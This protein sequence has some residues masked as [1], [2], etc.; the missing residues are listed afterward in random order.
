MKDLR[1]SLTAAADGAMIV[2]RN[3]AVVF[4]NRAA[5]RLLGYRAEEV[6]GRRCHEI[7]RGETIGGHALCSPS[8]P[9]A[10]RIACG[11]GVRNFDMLTHT[12]AGRAI[13]LNVSSFP[14]P[15][16]KK[17]QFVA[18][19]LFR[20]I[21]KLAKVRRIVEDLHAELCGGV[22]KSDEPPRGHDPPETPATLPLTDREREVLDQVARGLDNLSI[23]RRL[24]LSPKTVRNH[25][26]NI[27]TKLQVADRAQAIVRAREAGLGGSPE[28]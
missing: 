20:D 19:H 18:A 3:G 11:R 15:S 12:K 9:I 16:R 25:L 28:S 4:W 1:A 21:T 8:C 7:L 22:V 23:A 26:S 13:W 2:D 14:V 5:E 24:S 27:L 10:S 6:K 17:G